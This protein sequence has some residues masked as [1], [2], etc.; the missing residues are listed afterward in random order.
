[1]GYA[2]EVKLFHEN[3]RDYKNYG[4]EI[5]AKFHKKDRLHAVDTLF[6]SGGQQ[7][8]SI[9]VYCLSLQQLSQVPFHCVD[10]INEGLDRNNKTRLIN[11]LVNTV[12]QPNQSQYF[13]ALQSDEDL[14]IVEFNDQVEFLRINQ[15]ENSDDE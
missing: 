2:G 4:I 6:V 12:A 14:D 13:Y 10:V 8:L 9:A 7:S 15:Q 11:M 3:E 1:M 5:R